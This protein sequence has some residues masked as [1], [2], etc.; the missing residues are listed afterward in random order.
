VEI[1][2]GYP[3]ACQMQK[4]NESKGRKRRIR[5][6]ETITSIKLLQ[7]KADWVIPD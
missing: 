7:Q 3:A 2:F 5:G 6:D 1:G 4:C